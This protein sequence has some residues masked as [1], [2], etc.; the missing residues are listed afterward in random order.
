MRD[1][2]EFLKDAFAITGAV[3]TSKW[4]WLM[5]GCGVY[6]IFQAYLL[7]LPPLGPLSILVLPAGLIVYLLWDDNRRTKSQY[8]M[9]KPMIETTKWNVTG[10]VDE[11][12][13]TLTK[14]QILDENREKDRE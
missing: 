13:K 14:T 1:F 9:K 10:S 2:I 4:I 8:S 3:L 12:I 11:Y 7:F 6:F 5:I